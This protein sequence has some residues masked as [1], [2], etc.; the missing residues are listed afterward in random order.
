MAVLPRL[1]NELL[2]EIAALSPPCPGEDGLCLARLVR[3]SQLGTRCGAEPKYETMEA[4]L[5]IQQMQGVAVESCSW[6][7]KTI[8]KHSDGLGS[9]S[10]IGLQQGHLHLVAAYQSFHGEAQSVTPV[11]SIPRR[12]KK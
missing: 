7:D 9:E 11:S 4:N 6:M 5:C 2:L 12:H 1:P 3:W 8:K 10:F